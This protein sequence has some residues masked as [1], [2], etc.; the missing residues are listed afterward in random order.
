MGGTGTG[1]LGRH[2]GLRGHT[3]AGLC[4]ARTVKGHAA[5]AARVILGVPPP[6]RHRI[7]L[8]DLD[9]HRR[10]AVRGTLD[11]CAAARFNP[12]LASSVTN[13]VEMVQRNLYNLSRPLAGPGPGVRSTVREPSEG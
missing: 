9:L 5:D 4:R 6:H 8:V 13:Y 12:Q 1:V 7:P 2:R 10:A 3:R 11:Q